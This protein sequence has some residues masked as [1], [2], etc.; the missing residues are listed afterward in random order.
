MHRLFSII[1][2]GAC[3]LGILIFGWWFYHTKPSHNRNWELGQERLPLFTVEANR[4]KID[5]FRNFAWKAP[6]Q[7]DANYETRFFNL[8]L[9]S[10]LDV[11]ISHFDEFEGLGHIFLSFGFSDG[12]HVAVSLESRRENGEI[13][14]PLH[15]LFRQ[16]ELMYIVGSEEDLVGS[17]LFY[18]GE[19][20]YHYKTVASPQQT[21]SLL[22]KLGES[23]NQLAQTPRFYNTATRNCTNEITRQVEDVVAIDF[24]SSAKTFLPGYFD[25]VL[26]AM[27][28]L[29]AKGT[30]YETK[31]QARIYRSLDPKDPDFSKKLREK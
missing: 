3:T 25:E 16:Y 20:V 19:R 8:D 24:P 5:N 17:R 7:A 29:E 4:L 28:L 15:G 22:L 21:K 14:S 12:R 2:I 27:E 9:I 30:F 11:F 1:C 18:R 31:R 23:I 10:E 26:Y 6:L 13:F